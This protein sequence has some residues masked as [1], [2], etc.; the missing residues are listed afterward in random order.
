MGEGEEEGDALKDLKHSCLK[1]RIDFNYLAPQ[2]CT[3][4][5]VEEGIGQ[6]QIQ[7]GKITYPTMNEGKNVPT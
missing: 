1:V 2:L 6:Q 5:D 7:Q 3:G 4:A